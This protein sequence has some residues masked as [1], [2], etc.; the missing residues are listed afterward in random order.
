MVWLAWPASSVLPALSTLQNV[1]LC[2][3]LSA[4]E[5]VSV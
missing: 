1:M 4:K 5:N 3:P 2:W